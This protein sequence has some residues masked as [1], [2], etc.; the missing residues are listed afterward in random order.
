MC[1]GHQIQ[2]FFRRI[3]CLAYQMLVKQQLNLSDSSKQKS[4]SKT[5]LAVSLNSNNGKTIRLNQIFD[6]DFHLSRLGYI[7]K[8]QT[9]DNCCS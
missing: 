4:V 2:E 9:N 8:S 3:T 5:Q 1:L 7:S 6:L